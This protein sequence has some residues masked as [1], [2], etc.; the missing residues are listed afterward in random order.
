MIPFD[1]SI[2]KFHGWLDRYSLV[3]KDS[4]TTVYVAETNKQ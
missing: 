3:S 4:L 1:E 2:K